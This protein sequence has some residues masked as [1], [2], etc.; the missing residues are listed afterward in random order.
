M[1]NEQQWF[2][3]RERYGLCLLIYKPDC[4]G[5]STFA[6]RSAG[7]VLT[8]T[9]NGFGSLTPLPDCDSWDWKPPVPRR[10]RW[11]VTEKN[12]YPRIET[13]P[14]DIDPDVAIEIA[15]AA[16]GLVD[17]LEYHAAIRLGSDEPYN[18]LRKALEP[19]Q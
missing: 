15:A 19:K 6:Y 11:K 5:T 17:S 3:H 12:K 16:R 1:S 10:R 4:N 18:R 2:Q 14:G 9:I 13:R 7:K 8:F